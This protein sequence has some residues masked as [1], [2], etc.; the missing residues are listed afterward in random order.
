VASGG[1]PRRHAG[2]GKQ[3]HPWRLSID[4]A[5]DTSGH[6]P[7]GEVCVNPARVLRG[8]YRRL[9]AAGKPKKVAIIACMRTL[10]TILNAM[11]RTSTTWQ[12]NAEATP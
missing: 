6:H 2:T 12:Q 9:L 4:D 5:R 8:L 1:A 3:A 10:L 7:T 11:M